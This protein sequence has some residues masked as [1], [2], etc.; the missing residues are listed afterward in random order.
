MVNPDLDY[1]VNPADYN[2]LALD[3]NRLA[4]DCIVEVES[5]FEVEYIANLDLKQIIDFHEY[6]LLE[7]QRVL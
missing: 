3:Y 1:I 5:A 7:F 4:L 2:R 6:L